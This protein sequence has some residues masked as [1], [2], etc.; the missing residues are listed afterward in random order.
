[1][2]KLG[3]ARSAGDDLRVGSAQIDTDGF[4]RHCFESRFWW[5]G[6]EEYERKDGGVARKFGSD[7][8]LTISTLNRACFSHEEVSGRRWNLREDSKK[9]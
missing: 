4:A 3:C 7:I 8:Y 2:S 5:A 9:T 1:M 6:G